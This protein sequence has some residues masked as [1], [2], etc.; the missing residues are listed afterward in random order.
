MGTKLVKKVIKYIGVNPEA[1]ILGLLNKGM[2]KASEN[3]T[4]NDQV[5]LE[6]I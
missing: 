4:F 1:S 5:Y 2:N 3:Q 6:L